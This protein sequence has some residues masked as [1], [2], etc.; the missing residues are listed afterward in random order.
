M[1][2][3]EIFS[4]QVWYSQNTYKLLTIVILLSVHHPN[5]GRGILGEPFVVN[6]LTLRNILR[7]LYD[8]RVG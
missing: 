1:L 3:Y 6:P 4:E 8:V 2:A 5:R 7:L